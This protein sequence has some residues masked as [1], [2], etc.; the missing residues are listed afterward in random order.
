MS[1]DDYFGLA[2]WFYWLW[3]FTMLR[4]LRQYWYWLGNRPDYDQYPADRLLVS[5]QLRWFPWLA[6]YLPRQN[7]ARDAL[8]G[9]H[10]LT[11]SIPVYSSHQPSQ[12]QIG[13][14]NQRVKLPLGIWLLCGAILLTGHNVPEG[15]W[16]FLTL[17][18]C[19][20]F[21]V[22]WFLNW[23]DND[24]S[25]TQ[26]LSRPHRYIISGIIRDRFPHPYPQPDASRWLPLPKSSP[27]DDRER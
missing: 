22:I 4:R 8:P 13:Q 11:R 12:F 27:A 6:C 10:I 14:I 24:L 15:R 2:F 21:S 19:I 5:W 25:W 7:S 16:V 9:H 3:P 20:A 26:M 1:L 17:S 23:K 18:H